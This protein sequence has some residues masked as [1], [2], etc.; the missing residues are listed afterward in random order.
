VETPL[1]ESGR[2][3]VEFRDGLVTVLGNQTDLMSI[4]SRLAVRA[5]FRLELGEA[6]PGRRTLRIERLALA[7]ALPILLEGIE[8]QTD[9]EIDPVTGAHVLRRLQVGA[10]ASASSH[11]ASSEPAPGPREEIPRWRP[12]PILDPRIHE[13]LELEREERMARM[14]EEQQEHIEQ[15]SSR[16]PL[17]RADAASEIE[18]EGAGLEHLLNL[19]YEDPDPAVRAAAAGQLE[20]SDTH[21][22]VTALVN[23][24]QDEDRQVVLESIDA[25]EF[26]GDESIIPSLVPLLDSRDQE[27]REAAAE[28]I[29]FLE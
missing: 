6:R 27:I 10:M 25:L 8:Y 7:H 28:A 11:A 23:A 18:P 20:D 13:E 16:D 29:E 14:Q 12:Q 2:S 1:P 21:A 15:L 9:F 3:T 5:G 19:L 17:I 22:A 4:L 24:L 26:A